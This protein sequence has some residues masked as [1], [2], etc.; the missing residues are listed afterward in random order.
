METVLARRISATI[1]LHHLLPSTHCG[2]RKSTSTE[3][4]I[5]L[6][7][8][9]IYAVFRGPECEVASLLLLDVS[10]AF[11]NV[12]HPRLLHTIRKMGFHED[13]VGWLASYMLDRHGRMK[14]KE[15]IV[16][17]FTAETGIP[18]G[19][20]LSPIL[21][22]IYGHEL[23]RIGS[24]GV[25]KTGYIDDTCLAAGG[26]STEDTNRQLN[27]DHKQAIQWKKRH[28]AQFAPAKYHLIHLFR[29]RR[30]E[31]TDA[32]ALRPLVMDL[33]NG[34][35]QT[36]IPE[37]S[38]KYLGVHLDN[39]LSWNKHIDEARKKAAK[40]IHALR[41]IARSTW[42]V[43]LELMMRLYQATVLPRLLYAASSWYQINP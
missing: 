16:S 21:W 9:K 4:A 37:S 7:L 12:S 8:E 10:G 15:G 22:L 26:K 20:P 6:L 17:E 18:Q 1:E 42:G 27:E 35:T 11:D 32:E 38:V 28:G 36:I 24:S 3:H 43:S 40:Q 25:L 41:G 19:S 33:D 31:P 34:E 14:L 29:R 30:H 5:H 39:K 2:G 23:L 13:L